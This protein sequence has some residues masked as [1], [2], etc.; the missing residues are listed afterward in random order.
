MG[1]VTGLLKLPF[2]PVYGTV[3]V[4]DQVV[5]AAERQHYDPEPV[6]AQLAALVAELEEGRISEEEFD[7]R[8]DELLERLEWLEEY[9]RRIRAAGR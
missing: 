2:A 5:A 6:R 9:Q 8:E 7:R 4:L 3:W 1:L